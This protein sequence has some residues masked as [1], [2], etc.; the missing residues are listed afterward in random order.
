MAT[1][2]RYSWEQE[3]NKINIWF[4]VEPDVTVKEI[5]VRI[6]GRNVFIKAR[7]EVVVEGELLHRVD[8]SSLFWTLEEGGSFEL[9]V[10]KKRQEWWESLL[11][12]S[13]AVDVRKLAEERWADPSTLDDDEAREAIEKVM[14]KQRSQ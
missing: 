10:R 6:V 8:P 2:S 12:G 5:T 1:D 4:S 3:L 13:E 14:Y 7:D 9:E 11:V